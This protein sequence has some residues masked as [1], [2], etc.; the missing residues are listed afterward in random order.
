MICIKKLFPLLVLLMIG[1]PVLAVDIV[2]DGGEGGWEDL[3][4][5]GGNEIIEL[6][7]VFDGSDGWGSTVNEDEMENIIISG[8]DSVVSYHADEFQKDFEMFQGSTLT[9]SDGAVWTQSANDDWTENRW[10]ELDL[11]VLTLDGG[12][13][14][15]V[16]AVADLSLI[17]I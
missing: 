1:T 16:G 3:N 11:S 10:T 7:G 5:N 6:T 4:W 15:R 14:R 12:T 13:L 9:I 17:H 2:W 8:A